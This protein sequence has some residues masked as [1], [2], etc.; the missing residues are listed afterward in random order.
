METPPPYI[1]EDSLH[2]RSKISA[3]MLVRAFRGAWS[4]FPVTMVYVMYATVWAIVFIIYEGKFIHDSE[5][6]VGALWYLGGVGIPLSLAVA[7]WCEYLGR[8][9]KWPMIVANLLLWA[10][11][12]YILVS[13]TAIDDA[14]GV[15]RVA[16]VTALC[17][18]ILFVPSRS[19]WAWNFTNRQTCGLITAG[20][21]S[22]AF[23]LAVSI[24][25]VTVIEL[26]DIKDGFTSM[27]CVMAVCSG[28]I[29]TVIFLHLIPCRGEV[30]ATEGGY[31]ASKFQCGTAK[32]FVLM[33]TA[34]YMCILYVYGAKIFFTWDLPRGVLTFAVSGLSLAVLVTMFMLE[35]VR[36]THPT[37][38]LT[39]RALRILPVAMLPLLV[40]M[41]VGLAYRV[42]QYGL[43]AA[44]LYVI[45]FN[46]WCYAV[47]GYLS[48]RR[49]RTYNGVAISFAVV[50]VVTSILPYANLTDI[51]KF[52]QRESGD[53]DDVY[54]E[55]VEITEGDFS[56]H[57]IKTQSSSVAI[58]EGYGNVQYRHWNVTR[59]K[60]IENGVLNVDIDC[61]ITV[62]VDSIMRM[63]SSE[64]MTRPMILYQASGS[65]D[66]I[67]V[68]YEVKVYYSEREWNEKHKINSLQMTGYIFTKNE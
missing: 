57:I 29:P 20:V 59:P 34:V 63:K 3:D 62:P 46:L 30:E 26:F 42:N 35:G 39:L 14:W 4:R 38:V 7:L 10:D 32:Y 13:D 17:V 68:A 31:K 49:T 66:T 56:N 36:R 45:T 23:S 67:Y 54:V 19:L 51:G 60:V 28:T 24:I 48:L 21:F 52:M 53:T 65:S 33:I 22:W 41:S 61:R 27:M 16:V 18:A 64:S 6:V 58:P 25:W 1:G 9:L 43:T 15:G 2:R 47:F 11:C 37:D 12:V 8:K 44:R 55:T 50:F 5:R 40:L